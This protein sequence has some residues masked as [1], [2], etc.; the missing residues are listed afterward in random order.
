MATMMIDFL[1]V[2]CLS[3]FNG[4]LG[5]PLLKALKAVT[6]IHCLTIKFP[7]TVGIGQVRGQ[8]CDSRE[9]YSRSLELAKMAPE[10]PQSMEVE[11][12][13]QGPTETNIDPY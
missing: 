3:T 10:L 9:C 5:R 4:V 2:K 13:S 12:T 11:K 7:T 6:S 8:Q 1:V